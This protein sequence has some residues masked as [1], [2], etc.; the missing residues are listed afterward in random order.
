MRALALAGVLGATL[1]LCG[2]LGEPFLRDEVAFSTLRREHF[3]ALAVH[4]ERGPPSDEPLLVRVNVLGDASNASLEAAYAWLR[5][6]ANVVV[7]EDPRGAPLVLTRGDLAATSGRQTL[8]ATVPSGM[9]VEMRDQSVGECV[10]AHEILHFVGL[11]HVSDRRNIMY[12]HCSPHFLDRAT[13]DD[14]QRAQLASVE[15][16]VATTPAGVQVWA[17]R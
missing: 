10:A 15:E 17:T 6:H 9:A 13:L 8:G 16:I 11:K 5:G 2:A 3:D 4:T 1:V 14:N 12:A 7:V